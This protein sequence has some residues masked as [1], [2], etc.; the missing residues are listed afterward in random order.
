MPG[1]GSLHY[2]TSYGPMNIA[3]RVEEIRDSLESRVFYK[4]LGQRTIRLGLDLLCQGVSDLR[5]VFEDL[6][7][8]VEE[9]TFVAKFVEK[10]MADQLERGGLLA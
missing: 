4:C 9:G 2:P 10:I 3:F 6:P 1:V 5:G 7:S 8:R